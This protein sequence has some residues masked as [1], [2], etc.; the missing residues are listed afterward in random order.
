MYQACYKCSTWNIVTFVAVYAVYKI[1]KSLSCGFNRV[2]N[3][4]IC[5]KSIKR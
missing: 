1:W 5:G 3:I 4:L 2:M